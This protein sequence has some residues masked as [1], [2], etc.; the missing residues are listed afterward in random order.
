M[1]TKSICVFGFEGIEGLWRSFLHI[2]AHLPPEQANIPALSRCNG[3]EIHARP[4]I[5][6]VEI[7]HGAQAGIG[8]DNLA[9]GDLV[10]SA[11]FGTSGV[12]VG[13]VDGD[14]NV[15]ARVTETYPLALGS[16]GLPSVASRIQA[17]AGW[18]GPRSR[19]ET[20]V[21]HAT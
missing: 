1:I 4:N 7:L 3:R 19:S 5:T 6:A 15:L 8:N 20:V 2:C 16:N 10:I 14:L 9:N 13:V 12:K 11:D 17:R 18:S 21:P